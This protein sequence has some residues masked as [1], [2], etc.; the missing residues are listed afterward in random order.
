MKAARRAADVFL[1]EIPDRFQVGLITFAGAPSVEALPTT[2]KEVIRTALR[3][4]AIRRGTAVGDALVRA[5]QVSRPPNMVN[6]ERPPT[7]V[8]LAS[9]PDC[10]VQMFRV[11][12]NV[13]ATQFHPE[14][15][16]AGV[17]T[18]VRVYQHAGYF[19]PAEMEE[20]ITRVS[21][22]VVTE[23]SRLLANFVARYG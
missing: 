15:D 12:Q 14:L 18:R 10:P 20:L 19:P 4:A 2:D 21:Q 9:S 7:A 11:G 13:Y 22:A 23:P 16:V 17:V 3:T 8:L 1:A 5:L 6:S